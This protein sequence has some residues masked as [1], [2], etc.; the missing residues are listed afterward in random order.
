MVSNE[1][2]TG[3]GNICWP[4]AKLN[5]IG[6][7]HC[8]KDSVHL[9]KQVTWCVH[10]HCC[11]PK[12]GH[13]SQ[14]Y[15]WPGACAVSAAVWLFI[16]RGSKGVPDGRTDC[17]TRESPPIRPCVCARVCDASLVPIWRTDGVDS[18]AGSLVQNTFDCLLSVLLKSVQRDFLA[19]Q[20]DPTSSQ[21]GSVLE[22]TCEEQDEEKD[23]QWE[24]PV[25]QGKG[26]S[27][28]RKS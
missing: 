2:L 17:W 18:V 1:L 13:H 9:F 22:G 19:I 15:Q 21:H 24:S 4:Q 20:C 14:S 28:N 3:I 5:R 16:V 11:W 25:I 27:H 23:I 7:C 8:H 12:G 6:S 26:L 10:L